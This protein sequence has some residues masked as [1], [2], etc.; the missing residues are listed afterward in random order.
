M[1][2]EGQ[3][4]AAL[5]AGEALLNH[6]G[7]LRER[8]AFHRKRLGAAE[9][10]GRDYAAMWEMLLANN[11]YD[12]RL[13]DDSLMLFWRSDA[14]M[15]LRYCWFES[16]RTLPPFDEY[17]RSYL[18][19][20]LQTEAGDI[21]F[22]QF[23]SECEFEIQQA[24]EEERRS[25]MLRDAVTPLRYEFSPKQYVEGVHPASHLHVGISNEFRFACRRILNPM[26]F[27]ML[28]LRQAYPDIWIHNVRNPIRSEHS[29]HVREGL[30]I[31]SGDYWNDLDECEVRFE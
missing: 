3:F 29:V 16:P 15:A 25:A 23:L 21:E 24:F 5:N 13:F 30:P 6:L 7:L 12:I 26:S 14:E 18:S 8:N 27:I 22:E 2:P 10:A 28:V 19:G 9:L 4:H 17:A 20:I 11:D 31:V 1:V